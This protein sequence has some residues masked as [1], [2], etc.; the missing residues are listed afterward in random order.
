[1]TLLLPASSFCFCARRATYNLRGQR[2]LLAKKLS[3]Q[4]FT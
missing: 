1:M 3:L 4:R 2:V